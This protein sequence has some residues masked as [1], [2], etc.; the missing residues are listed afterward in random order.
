MLYPWGLFTLGSKGVDKAT[1]RIY[2]VLGVKARNA[3]AKGSGP[4]LLTI[5]MLQV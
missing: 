3:L 5:L 2:K 4:H 1:G